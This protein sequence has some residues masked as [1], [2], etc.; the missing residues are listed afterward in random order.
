MADD[1]IINKAASLERCVTRI[2]EVYAGDDKNLYENLTTQ[3]SILLNLQRACEVSIDLAMHVIRK[4][5]LGVPQD[6]REAFELLQANG[7]LDRE[8]ADALKR[9]VGFRNVAVHEYAGVK[10]DIVKSIMLRH[11]DEFLTFSQRLLR[12]EA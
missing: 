8:L 9:M 1:V 4:R 7:L 12:L 3:E 11:L 10:L 6:S 5:R 2:R